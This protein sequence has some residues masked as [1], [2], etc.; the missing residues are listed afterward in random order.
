M[1]D[2]IHCEGKKLLLDPARVLQVLL[3]KYAASF[4]EL[5]NLPE[6]GERDYQGRI[7]G[8]EIPW[9]A[10]HS[11]HIARGSQLN[12]WKTRL[13]ASCNKLFKET[14]NLKHCIILVSSFYILYI[15]ILLKRLNMEINYFSKE[16][17]FRSLLFNYIFLFFLNLFYLGHERIAPY[18]LEF[19][20]V[21]K[22][23][24]MKRSVT[25]L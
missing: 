2:C 3:S 5:I 11:S 25:S 10:L 18:G 9:S 24:N 14:L 8:W 16:V 21:D 7:R 1:L 17:K 4:V 12:I 19:M 22:K 13:I 20:I 23:R 15:T 6:E